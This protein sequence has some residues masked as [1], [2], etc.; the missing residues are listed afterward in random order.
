[1]AKTKRSIGHIKNLG[2]N[3]YLLRLSLGYDDF[4]KRLQPS[5]VVECN[6]DREAEKALHEFYNEREK[7]LSQSRGYTPNTLEELYS[8]W[9]THYVQ[10]KLKRTTAQWYSELWNRD[11]KNFGQLKLEILSATHI[12]TIIESIEAPRSRQASFKLLKAMLNKAQKWNFIQSNPCANIDTPKYK[13]P[14]KKALTT[15]QIQLITTNLRGQP[16]KYQAIFYFAIICSLRRQAIVALKWSDIDFGNKTF[17]V[18]RAAIQ[19][20]G[21]GSVTD[22]PKTEKSKVSLHLP[23]I[24][25]NILKAHK[26]EQLIERIKWGDKWHDED[27]IFTQNNGKMMCLATPSHWWREFAQPLGITDITFH[28][29]RHTAATHMIKNNIPIST[30]SGILGHSNITTTLNTYTHVIEDTK[31]SAIDQMADIITGSP[32]QTEDAI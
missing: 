26:K 11:L 19:L 6:S 28:G 14:E 18:N 8:Y 25:L 24:L 10:V 22:T 2:D 17:K 27:F 31:K 21:I 29:L 7:L 9:H 12:H 16:L 3:K 1:M 23:D 4:G 30:V 13:A 20:T 5:K 15:E 32:T